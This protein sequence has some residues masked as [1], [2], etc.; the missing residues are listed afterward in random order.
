M[1]RRARPALFLLTLPAWVGAQDRERCVFPNTSNTRITQIQQPSGEYNRYAGGGVFG[2][3]PGKEITLRADSMESYGDEGRVFLLGHVEYREP[4]LTLTSDRLTYHQFTERIVA[5]ERV[6]ARLPSGSTLRGNLV[7]YYRATETRPATRL[8]A[9]QRPTIAIV[10]KDSTGAVSPDT[11]IVLANHVNM[12]GDSLVYAGGDVVLTRPDV[13]AR[14]DSATID[15]EQ[16]LMVLMRNPS[17]TGRKDRPYTLTGT[18]IEMTSTDRKLSRVLALGNGKAESEDM[19]LASDTIDLRVADDLLQRAI[20]WGPSRA[21][22][23]S[24]TQQIAADS[25]DVAMPGQRLRE[26]HAVRGAAAEGQP[27]TSKFR[28]DTVDWLR[29][30][31]IVARFDTAT[32][33]DSTRQ[34]QLRELLAR[35]G[36]RSYYHMLPSDTTIR[37]AAINYVVGRQIV[38]AF[39]QRR[40]SKVTVT[41]RAAGVYVEPKPEPRPATATKGSAAPP[42]PVSRPPR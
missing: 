25:I 28:A 15:S 42:A 30:D 26:M 21:T 38:V 33:R 32:T 36:A 29:G 31:T 40:A 1:N 20:A 19:T 10:Q 11:L 5:T 17:I 27:D 12:I 4:R 6:V 7:D 35:G 23:S 16:E 13:E 18:R 8:Y 24:P 3:C 34:V 37:R 41:D 2:R 9:T 22:A 39:A 14:G